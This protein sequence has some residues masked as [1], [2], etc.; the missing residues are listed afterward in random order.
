MNWPNVPSY[1]IVDGPGRYGYRFDGPDFSEFIV[2]E[3]V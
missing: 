1:A 3:G 2:F